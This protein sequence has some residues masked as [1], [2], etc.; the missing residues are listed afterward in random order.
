M[1]RERTRT[2]SRFR[3]A[4]TALAATAPGL[5]VAPAPVHASGAQEPPHAQGYTAAPSTCFSGY[6]EPGDD[7]ASVNE[8]G[9][10]NKWL[11]CGYEGG[12]KGVWHIDGGRNPHPIA[13]DGA[14]DDN[15]VNCVMNFGSYGFDDGE[16]ANNYR[17]SM[18]LLN[19]QLAKLHYDKS[20][21][22]I[23]TVYTTGGGAGND[24][25]QCANYP[26]S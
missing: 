17:M 10:D 15:I 3:V 7:V 24:W 26:V 25:D 5:L 11:Y 8:T 12:P 13:R 18:R 20:T 19:G 22:E 16:D 9:P 14:D 21:Y 6:G 2:S 23:V 1:R 4:A